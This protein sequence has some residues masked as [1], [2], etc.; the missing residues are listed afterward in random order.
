L[1]RTYAFR[2]Q[3]R[4]YRPA[5]RC[6]NGLN[7]FFVPVPKKQN[8]IGKQESR[9]IVVEKQYKGNT[10]FQKISLRQIVT[11]HRPEIIG[12]TVHSIGPKKFRCLFALRDIDLDH[13]TSRIQWQNDP[14]QTQDFATFRRK[15]SSPLTESSTFFGN[16]EISSRSVYVGEA[17]SL[18]TAGTPQ[19]SVTVSDG[20]IFATKT[21]QN[22][23]SAAEGH[24]YLIAKIKSTNVLQTH[25]KLP[26][27]ES[28]TAFKSVTTQSSKVTI[29]SLLAGN[30]WRMPLPSP[31]RQIQTCIGHT[32][33]CADVSVENNH[34]VVKD[35]SRFAPGRALVVTSSEKHNITLIEIQNPAF[36]SRFAQIPEEL[37]C[38]KLLEELIWGDLPNWFQPSFTTADARTISASQYRQL[39]DDER[40]D[41]RCDVKVR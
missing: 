1:T 16:A 26:S 32:A 38:D 17:I 2:E 29:A 3:R 40:K 13:L 34:F 8:R 18:N 28:T 23:A 19:C 10:Y 6:P 30:P 22:H 21:A 24:D 39:T 33:F 11:N 25:H 12:A 41:V 37:S 4:F 15:Y 5:K 36:S 31:T 27:A 14:G 35:S 9:T 7:R 20:T